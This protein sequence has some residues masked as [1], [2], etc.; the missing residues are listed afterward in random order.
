MKVQNKFAV[1]F[2]LFFAQWLFATIDPAGGVRTFMGQLALSKNT[3]KVKP[4][5]AINIIPI[6]TIVVAAGILYL[7]RIVAGV[8]AQPTLPDESSHSGFYIILII[9]IIGIVAWLVWPRK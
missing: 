1:L 5:S 8:N 3:D 6:A 4:H 9:I 2:F 7:A